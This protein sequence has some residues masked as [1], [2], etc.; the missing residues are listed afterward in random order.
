MTSVS[1]FGRLHNR[2]TKR[3]A[4]W[5]CCVVGSV[6]CLHATTLP[7]ASER[8]TAS[9]GRQT[10]DRERGFYAT[11]LTSAKPIHSDGRNLM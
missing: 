11:V 8:R 6:L 9:V 7:R 5:E 10:L 1:A 3:D 4:F 2:P